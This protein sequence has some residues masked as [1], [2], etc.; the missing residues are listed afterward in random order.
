[1]EFRYISWGPVRRYIYRGEQSEVI[2][3]DATHI[4]VDKDVT[5]ILDRAFYWHKHIVEIIC[6]D[7][8]E[9]IERAAFFNCPRLR[10]VVMPGVKIVWHEAFCSCRALTD[11]EC[12]K[13]EIIREEA[14]WDC[15]LRSINL[16]SARIV[17]ERAFCYAAL[18]VV[19]FSS[20]LERIK[21]GAFGGCTSLERITIPLKD[22][23]LG[24]YDDNDDDI[25]IECEKL[26]QVD[27][28][29]EAERNETIAALHLEVWRSDV[30]EEIESI[31]RNLPS[32]SAGHYDQHGD[33]DDAGEK[34][35]S[36]R[37][38]LRSVLLKIIHY[39]EEHDRLLNEA[40]TTLQLALPQDIV[41]RC[42]LTFL[43]LPLYT[44][45]VDDL[46]EGDEVDDLEENEDG[47]D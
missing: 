4:I 12:D 19:K 11:V 1:M 8:V 33:V 41:N 5:V 30:N 46:E 23:L 20:K 16:L 47:S 28:V 29:A 37:T 18:T 3:G 10:R 36:I 35:R 39:Q 9:R 42:V 44:F 2:P 21:G 40:E 32:A 34:A 25:F 43:D 15:P 14:F 38:W 7:R 22:D 13:L 27:L 24:G 31:N 26:R 17:E 6:H 45:E